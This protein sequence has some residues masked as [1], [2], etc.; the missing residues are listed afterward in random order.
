MHDQCSLFF[1]MFGTDT[2]QT[3]LVRAEVHVQ[4][5]KHNTVHVQPSVW[6]IDQV[7]AISNI[8]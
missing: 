3:A 7:Y 5:G 6:H 1:G 4:Q 2:L 8:Q